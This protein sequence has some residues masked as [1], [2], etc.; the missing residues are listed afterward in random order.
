MRTIINIYFPASYAFS[1]DRPARYHREPL[2]RYAWVTAPSDYEVEGYGAGAN[3]LVFDNVFVPQQEQI[4]RLYSGNC[5]I[6]YQGTSVFGVEAVRL[7][8]KIPQCLRLMGV[9]KYAFDT[10]EFHAIL[11]GQEGVTTGDSLLGV[12]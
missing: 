6:V 10:P 4:D 8:K 5:Y 7:K 9:Y 1:P 11:V 12:A 3:L 2:E